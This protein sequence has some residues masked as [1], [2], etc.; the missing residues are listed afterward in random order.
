MTGYRIFGIVLAVI[1]VVAAVF[2]HWFA[3]LTG[4]AEPAPDLFEAVER[5]V[6]AGMVLGVGLTFI[7]VTSLRPWS[8]SIPSAV[9]YFMT[10]ALA[11]RLLGII[12]DGA[13]PKQWLLVGVEAVFM[14]G[15]AFWL[16]RSTG[17]APGA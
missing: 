1:G 11:A 8:T 13:V 14:A 17:S 6:R 9:F 12:V 4:A 15:A 7:A 10:G 16:W 2:P 3:P 5:R